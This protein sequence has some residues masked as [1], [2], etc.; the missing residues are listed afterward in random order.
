[1]IGAL[2]R[3]GVS[4]AIAYSGS[5][6][7]E[8][9]SERTRDDPVRFSI[10]VSEPVH[11]LVTCYRNDPTARAGIARVGNGECYHDPRHLVLRRPQRAGARSSAD[12]RGG[13]RTE[14]G[15]R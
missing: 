4:P 3:D 11:R 9:Y 15:G 10:T 6:R 13:R 2:D 5:L 8:I 1:M 7:T 14:A 12:N